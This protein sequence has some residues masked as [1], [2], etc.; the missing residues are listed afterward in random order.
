MCREE[1]CKGKKVATNSIPY[2]KL[3]LSSSP[4]SSRRKRGPN[5]IPITFLY[6][7]DRGVG[8]RQPINGSPFC[9][10]IIRDIMDFILLI[11]DKFY[12]GDI[13]GPTIASRN[14]S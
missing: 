13:K 11:I 9:D 5:S 14:D 10:Q 2:V 3:Q 1:Q 8:L 7:L 4:G 6:C 12:R